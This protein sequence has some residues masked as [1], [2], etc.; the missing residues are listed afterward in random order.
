MHYMQTFSKKFHEKN[1]LFLELVHALRMMTGCDFTGSRMRR[2]WGSQFATESQ[3]FESGCW[4]HLPS[5]VE[6]GTG[7][8]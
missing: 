6:E 2:D 4:S 3:G 1:K 5:P 7:W 8:V